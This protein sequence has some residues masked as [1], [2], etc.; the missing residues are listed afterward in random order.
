MAKKNK[1]GG[2][3]RLPPER[4]RAHVVGMLVTAQERRKIVNAA[5][6]ADMSISAWLRW[7]VLSNL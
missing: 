6:K 7:R 5:K 4:R 1:K 2:R 3:P